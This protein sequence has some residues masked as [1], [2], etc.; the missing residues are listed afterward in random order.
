MVKFIVLEGPDGS[1]SSTQ[2]SFLAKKME[3]EGHAY[4]HTNQPSTG[5]IGTTIRQF[6]FERPL[7]H[8]TA[9]QLMYTADRADHIESVIKPALAANKTV[10]CERY[11]LS[12]ILYTAATGGD[13]ELLTAANSKFIQP[14]LTIVL[15]PPFEVCMERIGRRAETDELEKYDFQKKLHTLYSTLNSPNTIFIDS[16]GAKEQTAAAIWKAV[17]PVVAQ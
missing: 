3:E 13:T 2:A 5:K 10:L 16:S 1:G 15:L 8:P 12:T 7:P 17:E 4:I 9:F 11:V 14:D 6:L